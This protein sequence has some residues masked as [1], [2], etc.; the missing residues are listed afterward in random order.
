LLARA[1]R[2]ILYVDEVNLLDDHLV[3]VLLDAAASGWN[4]VERDGTSRAHPAEITLVGTMNPEEGDL[5]PQLR[6]RFALQATVSGTDD[7][8]ERVTI[9]ERAL[10]ESGEASQ[11]DTGD[12]AARLTRA[13]DLLPR[14]TLPDD[15]LEEIVTCCRDA[16]VEGHRAD[17]ATARAARTFAALEGRPTVTETDVRRAAELALPHR[18]K[19]R[20]FEDAPDAGEVIDDHFEDGDDGS[21]EEQTG[22]TASEDG[23]D[24]D[25]PADGDGADG[26]GPEEDRDTPADDA[27]D[28]D[29]PDG[30]DGGGEDGSDESDP[31][32]S[33]SGPSPAG[34]EASADGSGEAETGP[35]ADDD[36]GDGGD[37]GDANGDDGSAGDDTDG[38]ELQPATP[39][40]PGQARE[41]AD[42]AAPDVDP[43]SAPADGDSGGSRAAA[44]PGP[45]REGARVRTERASD[46]HNVDAAAS[47]RAAAARGADGVESRDLRRSVRAGQ[48]GTLVVFALD[49]SASMRPAMRTAKGVAL[50]LL[51]DAYQQRDAVS[52]VTFAGEDADVVL[53][54]TDSVSL[55][56]RHLKDVPAGDRTPLP[57]GLRTTAE[58]I[59]RADPDAAVVV[60]LTDGRATACE[61]P[62]AETQEAARLLGEC[63]RVLVVDAGDGDGLV[64]DVLTATGG[65]SV[66]LAALSADRVAAET[67]D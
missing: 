32:D 2:G 5:R 66:P 53:P 62:T 37:G 42:A 51:E 45:D 58:V 27:P 13:R 38:D 11:S 12:S 17:I 21:G 43:P 67:P 52:V 26:D 3:D 31:D 10:G 63:A 35:A 7:L 22:E 25:E 30:P 36:A 16:G 18:L 9:V 19:S 65:E 57:A 46:G 23:A 60:L 64:S 8:D 4:R 40:V 61:R 29:A 47:V 33:T 49:A 34:V 15:L 28:D 50:S 24:G 55:A 1:N 54:P 39:L 59:E 56:S 41:P 14:V 6:D 20:P 44:A 48:T